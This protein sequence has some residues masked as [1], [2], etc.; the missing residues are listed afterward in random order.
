MSVSQH[1]IAELSQRY[2]W[3]A[4]VPT[5]VIR[6]GASETDLAAAKTLAPLTPST[7]ARPDVLRFV[8]TG[9][10]G[11]IMPH[12]LKVL[13]GGLSL[14][15]ERQPAL[16]ARLQF[17]FLGTS[18]ASPGFG[19]ITVRPI[20]EE[21]GVAHQVTEIPHRL[22]HLE[23][24]RLQAQADVLLLLGSS[25]LAYSPSKIY[26]Y[27][28]S[29]RPMLAIVFKKSYLE[30]IIGELSCACTISFDELAAKTTAHEQLCQFFELALAGFPPGSLPK[31]NHELFQQ[32]F[33]ARTL[34]GRQCDL[35]TRAI[36]PSSSVQL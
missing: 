4:G 25:D 36:I 16:S 12:A 21:F 24:L 10:A 6:F 26:P 11:P 9:A 2:S 30:E 8:Y 33:L 35:F 18:Y 22:G 31:R 20:A 14:F 7:A 1:Y 19:K 23:C 5:A 29:G 32:E 28:L 13:F 27:F 3:F 34:T 17:D 15:R